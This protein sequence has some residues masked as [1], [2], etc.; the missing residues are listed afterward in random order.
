MRVQHGCAR[1][2]VA[3][4]RLP[5]SHRHTLLIH[6]RRCRAG[7]RGTRNA[8]CPA[9]QAAGTV[10]FCELLVNSH[11]YQ[12]SRFAKEHFP[13]RF[14]RP[15]EMAERQHRRAMNVGILEGVFLGCHVGKTFYQR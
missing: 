9:S 4:A 12:H 5:Y 1:V 2:G 3:Q 10:F 14:K 11:V 8:E 13:V 15:Y 7:K 6:H